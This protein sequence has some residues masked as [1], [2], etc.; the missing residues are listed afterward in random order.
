MS[1]IL[2]SFILDC[3]KSEL[4]IRKNQFGGIQGSG[5]AHASTPRKLATADGVLRY[6]DESSRENSSINFLTASNIPEPPSWNQIEPWVD[7][8][9]DDVNAGERLY[10]KNAVSTFSQS[11][12]KKR[13][14]ATACQ[15][16]FDRIRTNSGRL[17]MKINESKTRL[18]CITAAQN[19]EVLAFIKTSPDT[20]IESVDDMVLLGYA[21]DS[22]PSVAA[23]VRLIIRKFNIR[24]WL[25]RHLISAGV[26]QNDVSKIYSTVICPVLEYATPVYSPLLGQNQIDEI[27]SL[28]R[29]SLKIIFG[30]KTSYSKALE[31]SGLS[32]L[33]QQRCEIARKFVSK[34]ALNTKF[35]HWLPKHQPYNYELRNRLVYEDYEAHSDRLHKSPLY[36]YR[37][38]LNNEL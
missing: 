7:K 26:P 32:T 1:K 28:Q 36:L 31:L 27:E 4:T 29:R 9:V 30:H 16:F 35:N 10:L 22:K 34:L 6:V 25:L 37:R 8:Y 38:M 33:E 21:F 14:L 24:S 17:G 15:D 2:E 12:E 18:F 20:H 11:K 23:H 5:V 13:I 3:L 19:S